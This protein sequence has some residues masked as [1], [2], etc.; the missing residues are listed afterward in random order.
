[1]TLEQL[2]YLSDIVGVVL[3]V[4][5][6]IYV[7]QQLRQNTAMMSASVIGMTALKFF[8]INLQKLFL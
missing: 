5:S 3:I 4:A 8:M 6:L 7:A 1:M 2:S